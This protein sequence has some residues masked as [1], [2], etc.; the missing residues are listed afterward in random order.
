MNPIESLNARLFLVLVPPVDL[1]GEENPTRESHATLLFSFHDRWRGST[2]FPLGAD[3]E[4][5][6]RD[7]RESLGYRH[8]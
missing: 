8:R 2:P 6:A 1:A 5:N 7:V 3:G 4:D